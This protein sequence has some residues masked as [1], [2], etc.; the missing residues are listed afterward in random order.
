MRLFA[1]NDDVEAL[2]RRLEGQ[3][4]ELRL[5]T[6]VRLAW[7]MRQRDCDRALSLCLEVEALMES[8]ALAPAVHSALKARLELVRGE[9]SMLF[10][11]L[12]DAEQL[13]RSALYTFQMLADST[14]MG[15][16][17]WLLGHIFADRGEYAQVVV[18]LNDALLHYRQSGDIH[19]VQATLARQ[20]VYASF[21]DPVAAGDVLDREFPPAAPLTTDIAA[22]VNAARANVAGLTSN[23]AQSIK[24]DLA[25]FRA[26]QESGQIRQ[27]LVSLINGAESFATLG[28]LDS[29]LEWCGQALALARQMRWPATV[30]MSLMQLGDVMRMLGRHD[31]AR[32]H[33]KEALSL[34]ESLSGSRNYHHILEK[35]GRLALSTGEHAVALEW[36]RRFEAEVLPH[37]E[38]DL[39]IKA[40]NAQASVLQQLEMLPQ[41]QEKALA[42]LALARER[43]HTEGQVQSLTALARNVPAGE[44][45]SLPYIE[46]ALQTARGME[47]YVVA[48]ELLLEAASAHAQA[49]NFE[50]AYRFAMRA[51]DARN[52]SRSSDAQSRA[53]AMQVRH[54]VDRARAEAESHRQMAAT[55]ETLGTVG[56]EITASLND[57]DVFQALHR[58]VNQLLDATTFAVYLVDEA[59][60]NL[61]PAFAM[62][63]GKPMPVRVVALANPTSKSARSARKR[64]EIVVNLEP[65]GL[66]PHHM[67]GTLQTVSLMYFPLIA[68]DR[69]LGV[70]SIQSQRPNAYGDSEQSIFR[71]LCAY[72]AIALDNAAAYSTA[73]KAQQRADEAVA[74]LRKT[75]EQLLAQNAQLERLSV[76]DQLTGLFNRLQLDRALEEEHSRNMRYGTHFCLLLLDVDNF[77]AVN[78]TYGHQTGDEVLIGVATVLREGVREVDVVGRWGG[79]EF[80][81]IC[82]ETLLPGALVLAEKL[83]HTIE[84]QIFEAVGTMTASLGVAE[85]RAGE[86]LTET[87]SRADAALYHAKRGGRNRVENG[88]ALPATRS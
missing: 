15:D 86:V 57:Q 43:S 56:R 33:L 12:V 38:A 68:G 1:L 9:I 47:G 31:E 37:Q 60:K 6:L 59:H 28:D 70:M 17:H 30:G 18:Q 20:Q 74:Q 29:A 40:W 66:D 63:A 39:I 71:A 53:L 3:D 11:R 13:G 44:P 50:S 42:A 49:G 62:E 85:F 16:A 72:G 5:Q 45:V 14:G 25:A 32:A 77:K 81:I 67:P 64:Q 26:G 87:I 10:A 21:V 75:Q 7:G 65:G 46:E 83:R 23:P 82:R 48:P 51:V 61:L 4:G 27:A 19:R 76:T 22:W 69:L 54:E 88:E 73:A 80:L 52:Q 55:L 24:Y 35:L 41:A 58:H 8:L 78:D 84:S 2:S 79:E 36:F 34:A